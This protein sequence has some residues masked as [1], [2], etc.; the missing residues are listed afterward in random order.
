MMKRTGMIYSFLENSLASKYGPWTAG[1]VY[2]RFAYPRTW[3]NMINDFV[4]MFVTQVI[5]TILA[6]YIIPMFLAGVVVVVSNVLNDNHVYQVHQNW[7]TFARQFTIDYYQLFTHHVLGYDGSGPMLSSGKMQIATFN[8]DVY[9]VVIADTWVNWCVYVLLYA[10]PIAA[11]CL[12]TLFGSIILMLVVILLFFVLFMMYA[13]SLFKD[14]KQNY[15]DDMS[16]RIRRAESSVYNTLVYLIGDG[17]IRA[18]LLWLEYYRSSHPN[19]PREESLLFHALVRKFSIGLS[20]YIK[21]PHCSFVK[22]EE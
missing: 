1:R 2:Y 8:G 11:G 18:R 19:A 22:I 6:A 3:C 5:M 10:A 17:G 13:E 12:V 4:A 16:P 21:H 9:N 20:N 14:I 7:D 15:I